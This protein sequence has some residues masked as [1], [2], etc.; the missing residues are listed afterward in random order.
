MTEEER[1]AWQKEQALRAAQRVVDMEALPP[2][3]PVDILRRENR[4]LLALTDA[5]EKELMPG[6]FSRL[7]EL[8]KH[9]AKTEELLMPML[10]RYGVSGPSR[11]IWDADDKIKQSLS[12]LLRQNDAPAPEEAAAFFASVRDV[13]LREEK[14]LF[15]LTLRYLS[16]REWLQVYRDLPEIGSAFLP[17]EEVPRW[18]EGEDFIRA[19]DAKDGKRLLSE[20]RV[21]L[22]TGTL[23]VAQLA[24]IF[25]LLPVDITF[26]DTEDRLR[27]FFNE[28]KVFARP[29]LALGREIWDCHPPRLEPVIRK[30]LDDFREKRKTDH[31]VWQR[32][33]GRPVCVRYMAVYGPGGDYMGTV[34]TVQDMTDALRHFGDKK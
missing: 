1:Q 8:R 20:G 19:E 17:A 34:E 10:Y 3:H 18:E 31:T 12:A 22:P 13:A 33:A 24:G 6:G 15:P 4:A 9:Y 30:L 11:A 29:L 5:L 28:G 25:R 16:D 32:I 14:V 7:A 27:F 2:G 23:T 26:I 21:E